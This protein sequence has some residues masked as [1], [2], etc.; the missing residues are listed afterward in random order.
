MTLG[1]LD[2]QHGA[3]Q[4]RNTTTLATKIMNHLRTQDGY[5]AL[6]DVA[7]AFPSVPRPM[8]TGIVKEAGAPENIIRMLGEIYQHTP[9]VL[10]LYGRDL[11]IRPTRGMKEGCPLPPTL[12][13]LYYDI[14]LKKTREQCPDACLYVF[15]DDI[16]V[17][18]PTTDAP[19]H[20]LDALHK[21]VH[22]MG[23]RFNKDKTEVYHRTK[24]YNLE[25]ITLQP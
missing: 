10:S 11:P 5:V 18:A 16:A 17:R 8:L 2:I 13:L 12:F 21:V 7:K 19:L 24:N 1:L 22:T 25:P 14:L 4:S 15:V 9:A 3:L 23:L 20:T 6:L